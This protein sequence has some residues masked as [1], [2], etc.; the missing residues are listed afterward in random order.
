MRPDLKF[1]N[2]R[3][4]GGTSVYQIEMRTLLSR[5]QVGRLPR[6]LFVLLVTLGVDQ[7][8][9]VYARSDLHGNGPFSYL[10]GFI[11]FEFAENPGAFLSVGSGMSET[12]RFAIFSVGVIFVLI[13][14]AWL[15]M[16][17]VE[18]KRAEIW[19]LSLLLAGG[20]G[21][22]ID[23]LYKGTVTDFVQLGW[24]P[25]RTGIFNLADVAIMAGVALLFLVSWTAKKKTAK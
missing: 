22:L 12:F 8:T 15:L 19:G 5:L 20:I 21:N 25:L 10:G 9:K 7:W 3:Q 11:R 6:V 16:F 17:R 14:A 24:D 1:F 13:W 4:K 18:L 23:R 2:R